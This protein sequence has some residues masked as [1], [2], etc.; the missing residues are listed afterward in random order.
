MTLSAGRGGRVLTG[1]LAFVAAAGVL[2][3]CAPSNSGL[4]REAATQLQARVLEVTAAASQN[5]PA[6]ALKALEG[7]ETDLS[8]AQSKGQV[9]E[10]RRR[11]ITTVATAV[12]ADLN[13]ILAAQQAAPKAAQDASNA[14]GQPTQGT[15]PTPQA[16]VSQAAP[17]PAPGNAGDTGKNNSDKG[18]GKN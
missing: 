5:D 13:D 17:A 7:L 2:S 18:K 10:E 9:S 15:A 6:T 3:G 4:Q 8:A 11:S 14:A 1:C 16:P 12:R